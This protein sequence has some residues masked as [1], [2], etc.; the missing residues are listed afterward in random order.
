MLL[1][2][3]QDSVSTSQLQEIYALQTMVQTMNSL[4]QAKCSE[5]NHMCVSPW[6]CCSL[7]C[8]PN[9][10]KPWSWA[11]AF[12]RGHAADVFLYCVLC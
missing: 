1:G 7:L 12:R 9:L 4:V 11:L 3:L 8:A 2:H 6:L 5:P 10:H